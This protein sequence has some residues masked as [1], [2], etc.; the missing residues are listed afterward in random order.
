MTLRD[1]RSLVRSY[2]TRELQNK[3]YSGQHIT[4]TNKEIDNA[5]NLASQQFLSQTELLLG[6]ETVTLTAGVGAIVAKTINL[7]RIE[8]ADKKIGWLYKQSIKEEWP[9][10]GV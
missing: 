6:S 9:I 7:H 4:M 3:Q 8:I 1:I 2:L 10:G 5:I